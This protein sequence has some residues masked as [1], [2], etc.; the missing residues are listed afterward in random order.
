MA[1]D[2]RC[3][4][5]N[6]PPCSAVLEL[7][8]LRERAFWQTLRPWISGFHAKDATVRFE[9]DYPTGTNRAGHS[10]VLPDG[11]LHLAVRDGVIEE[12]KPGAGK[13]FGILGLHALPRRLRLDF[14]DLREPGLAFNSIKGTFAIHDDVATTENITL[15]GPIGRMVSKGWVD[16]ERGQLDQHLAVTPEIGMELA[17]GGLLAGGPVVGGAILVAGTVLHKPLGA[18]TTLRYHVHGDWNAP[19][20]EGEWERSSPSGG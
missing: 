19:V 14:S 4:G 11:M 2:A 1:L 8:A 6:Q 17:L 13:L 15:L 5:T 20:I 18:L 7:H 9:G 12:I 10:P 16:L 3:A